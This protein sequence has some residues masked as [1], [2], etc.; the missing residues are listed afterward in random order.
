M[1]KWRFNLILAAVLGLSAFHVSTGA[2]AQNFSGSGQSWSSTWGFGSVADRS[3]ALQQAQIIKN[4]EQ[5]VDPTSVV[6][7]NNYVTNNTVY[8]NRSNYVEANAGGGTITTDQHVVGNDEIGQ[9]TYAVGSLNTGNT[10]IDV[11]GSS[12]NISATN[13]ADNQGCVDGSVSASSLDVPD[14]LNVPTTGSLLGDVIE[15]TSG[16]VDALIS[17][18]GLHTSSC[19]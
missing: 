8:D 2:F 3:L 9:Q 6:N 19:F 11:T 14:T 18:N 16:S 15:G 5:G 1:S 17:G 7:T 12:N 13:A 10:K 4:A